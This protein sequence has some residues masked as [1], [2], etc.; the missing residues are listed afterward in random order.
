MET[1]I[2]SAKFIPPI[3]VYILIACAICLCI[4]GSVTKKPIQI[5]MCIDYMYTITCAVLHLWTMVT[6]C[7]HK[8]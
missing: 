1:F 2:V 4:S 7:C 8:I 6:H 3:T 5:E